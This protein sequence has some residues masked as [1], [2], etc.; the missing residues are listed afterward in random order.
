MNALHGKTVWITA[1]HSPETDAPSNS[2]DIPEWLTPGEFL[3]R[4]REGTP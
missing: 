3:L 4:R 1:N 2:D